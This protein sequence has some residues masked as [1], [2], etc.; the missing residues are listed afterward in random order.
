LTTKTN[1]SAD[2]EAEAVAQDARL[3]I[4]LKSISGGFLNNIDEYQRLLLDTSSSPEG[5]FVSYTALYAR[6][7]AATTD[8]LY[9]NMPA[10]AAWR[11]D[12]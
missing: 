2:I 12:L 3:P 6:L 8:P 11:N 1:Y 7:K 5:T 10:A 9:L 4:S